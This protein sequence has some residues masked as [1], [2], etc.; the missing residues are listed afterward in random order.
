[1]KFQINNSTDGVVDIA[2]VGHYTHYEEL[3]TNEFRD[4]VKSFPDWAQ[5]TPWMC[6]FESWVY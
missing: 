6:T 5:V 1:M 3:E 2:V 4:F